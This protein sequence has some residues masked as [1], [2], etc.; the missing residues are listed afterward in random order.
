MAI[1]VAGPLANLLLAIVLYW[2]LFVHGV[3]GLKPILGDVPPGT[4]AATAQMHAGE[5]ILSIDGEPVPSWQ[6]LHW[7][8]LDLVLQPDPVQD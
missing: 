8:L 7:R 3:P 4:P 2:A 1:V 6:E 5:T